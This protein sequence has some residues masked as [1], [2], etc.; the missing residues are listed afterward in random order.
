MSTVSTVTPSDCSMLTEDKDE[1]PSEERV[2]DTSLAR[3]EFIFR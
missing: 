2:V 3:S 1:N